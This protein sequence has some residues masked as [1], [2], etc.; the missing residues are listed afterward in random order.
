MAFD[1]SNGLSAMGASI[2]SQA[3]AQGL[4]FMREQLEEQ[5]LRLAD[6]LAGGQY[7][8]QGKAAALVPQL[9]SID[10]YLKMTGHAGGLADFGI[11]PNVAPATGTAAPGGQS[12]PSAAPQGKGLINSPASAPSAPDAAPQSSDSGGGS[13]AGRDAFPNGAPVVTPV[14]GKGKVLGL[15]LPP[16]WTMEQA[17]IAGPAA[18][19]AAWEKW[20]TPQNVRSNAAITFFDFATGTQKSLYQQPDAPK[21]TLFD[22]STKSFVKIGNADAAIAGAAYD[23]AKGKAQGALP[24]ELTKIGATGAQTRE[25]EGFK[26]G[27]DV[28]TDLVPSYDPVTEVT[29][30]VTK[31]EALKAARGG[32][33][34]KAPPAMGGDTVINTAGKPGV[35]KDGSY[36]TPSGTIIPPAPKLPAPEGGFQAAPSAADKATQETYAPIIKSWQDSVTPSVMAEQRFQAIA[37]AMKATET[38]AWASIKQDIAHSLMAHGVISADTAKS[39]LG[40]DVG[41]A[42]IILKNNFGTALNTLSAARLGRI[43]QN[44]IF[45]MQKNLPAIGNQP[46]A[47]MAMIAQGIGTSRFQQALANDW[48]IARQRGYADP[49]T[50]EAEWVK[51]NPLQGFIDNAQKEVGS[52]KGMPSAFPEPPPDAVRDLKMRGK[53]ASGQFDQVFGPGAADRVFG[54]K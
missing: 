11:S 23:E 53:S 54:S 45:A 18:L 42:Q 31:A 7:D 29:T 37:Q 36:K 10:K 19:A 27:L 33:G 3:G 30:M 6:Q 28:A 4:E 5:K 43:T 22:P 41:E 39:L 13:S 17:Q 26:K 34:I 46:E 14:G 12:S 20:S 25:T 47:N 1:I 48:N 15:A 2:S 44:E 50:Y 8:R 38:G 16:G 21:G 49:L 40:A 35:Q 51:A 52:L 24:A 9:Q 32:T